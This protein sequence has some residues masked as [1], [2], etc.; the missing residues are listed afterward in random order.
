MEKG[1]IKRREMRCRVTT[2]G[3]GGGGGGGAKGC[4]TIPAHVFWLEWKSEWQGNGAREPT[5]EGIY[6]S[7][8]KSE[9]EGWEA[10]VCA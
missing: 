3:G 2:G 8:R 1:L 5:M 10:G 4:K 6:Q 7:D 9:S